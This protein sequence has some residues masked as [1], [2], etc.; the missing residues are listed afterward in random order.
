MSRVSSWRQVADRAAREGQGAFRRIAQTGSLPDFVIIG[1]MRSGTSSLSAALGDHPAIA[2]ATVKE[3]H[4]FDRH[5]DR[6]STWYRS[7][8]PTPGQRARISRATGQPCL[9][10][11]ATPNYLFHPPA[12]A[13]IAE[14]L[15]E[16]RLIAMLRDPVERAVSGYYYSPDRRLHGRGMDPSAMHAAF[17]A[18]AARIEAGEQRGVCDLPRPGDFDGTV[19]LARGIYADQFEVYLSVLPRERFLIVESGEYFA[20]PSSGLDRVLGFLGLPPAAR[21]P[22]KLRRVAAGS[23]PAV[24]ASTIAFLRDFYR[25]WN[26][27]LYDLLGQDLGWDDAG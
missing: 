22:G 18:E 13:R 11:D 8:F 21:E 1:A 16:A 6:G 26:Q 7:R 3:L 17:E 10:G 19:Y 15:P 5:V 27:R 12:A 2:K 9:S 20:D 25:P 23:H 14:L 4:Y 24:D